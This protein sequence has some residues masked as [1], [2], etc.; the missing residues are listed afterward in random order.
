[1]LFPCVSYSGVV[2]STEQLDV[3]GSQQIW[4]V[5]SDQLGQNR[6]Q[7]C[8]LVYS[9]DYDEAEEEQAQTTSTFQILFKFNFSYQDKI[10]YLPINHHRDVP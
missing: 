5:N 2:S 8:S 10:L 7:T 1:M 6:S 3:W 4:L 9:L